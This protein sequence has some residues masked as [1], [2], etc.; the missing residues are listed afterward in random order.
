MHFQSIGQT[1]K[2]R[3]DDLRDK[4]KGKTH[5]PTELGAKMQLSHKTTVL[6]LAGARIVY[7]MQSPFNAVFCCFEFTLDTSEMFWIDISRWMIRSRCRRISVYFS[8]RTA[9]NFEPV[10]F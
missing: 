5:G 9:H 2:G 10:T 4:F 1:V 8:W 7:F 6:V 3:S